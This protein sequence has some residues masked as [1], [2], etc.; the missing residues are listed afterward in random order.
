[1]KEKKM[2]FYEELYSSEQEVLA[3]EIIGLEKAA[4]DK[5]FR[6]DSFDLSAPCGN[7]STRKETKM[8]RY[9]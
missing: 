1:M 6:G 4:L 3:E 7:K 8:G 2:V 5:W 9:L